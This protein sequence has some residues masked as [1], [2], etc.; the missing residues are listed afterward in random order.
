MNGWEAVSVPM[1]QLTT[2]GLDLTEV[3]TGLVIWASNFGDTVFQID[4][5]RFTGFDATAEPPTAPPVTVDYTLTKLGLGSYSDTINPASYRCVYDYGFWLYN[6]G[7]IDP[8]DLGTCANPEN[9]NPVKKLPRISGAAAEKKGYVASLVGLASIW[10]RW[11]Y[12]AR[13]D[14]SA[15]FRKRCS[16]HW[17]SIWIESF[18]QYAWLFWR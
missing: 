6:A 13:P 11:L 12:H 2:A 16:N 9:A 18:Y 4:N 8:L 5:V 3:N 17:N 10:C 15:T 7:V 14:L 1:S